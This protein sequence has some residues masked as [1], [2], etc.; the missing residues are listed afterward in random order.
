MKLSNAPLN[1]FPLTLAPGQPL[2]LA[3][4]PS[5][6]LPG[7]GEL[8]ASLDLS[9]V[10]VQPDLQEV[11]KAI[12]LNQTLE[13]SLKVKVDTFDVVVAKVGQI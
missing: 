2:E 12:T 9:E 7:S 3:L 10:T 8:A 11:L 5:A 4:S 13:S 6:P 1:G